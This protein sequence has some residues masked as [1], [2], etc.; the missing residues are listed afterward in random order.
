MRCFK[1][2]FPEVADWG[3]ITERYLIQPRRGKYL[4]AILPAIHAKLQ[5]YRESAMMKVI[6]RQLVKG[7]RVFALAGRRHVLS[8]EPSLRA[9]FSNIK[10]AGV[11]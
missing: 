10:E 3:D 6:R 11:N 1:T 2:D 5:A 4:P 9:F 7:R 8:L